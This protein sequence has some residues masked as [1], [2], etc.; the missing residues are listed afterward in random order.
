MRGSRLPKAWQFAL[1][2][3]LPILAPAVPAFASS[4]REAPGIARDPSA[5]NTDAYF[6]RDPVDPSRLVMI[7]NWI[8][9]EEPAGG[10]NF[11]HF[12][13]SFSFNVDSN[14]DGLEDLVYRAEFA[15]SANEHLPPGTAVSSAN[16]ISTCITRTRQRMDFPTSPPAVLR[17]LEARTT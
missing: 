4:H 1:L 2:A 6:F 10:P 7:S 9:L 8:P 11:F 16:R 5:D 13:D 14:G 17:L 15:T 3:L 12:E